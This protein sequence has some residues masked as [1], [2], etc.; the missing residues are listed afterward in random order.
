[1][2]VFQTNLPIDITGHSKVCY[3]SNPTR[4]FCGEQTISGSYVSGTI[5]KAW[6]I[7]LAAY[8]SIKHISFME[9]HLESEKGSVNSKCTINQK[10]LMYR[11]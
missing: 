9:I 8:Y 1:M 4:T 3:F 11:D 6:N 7:I 5:Q 2:V 10:L